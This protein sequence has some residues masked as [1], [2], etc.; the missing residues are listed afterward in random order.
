MLFPYNPHSKLAILK[1]SGGTAAFTSQCL[2]L[3]VEIGP[4]LAAQKLGSIRM[5]TNLSP[6]QHCLLELHCQS[7][8]ID[9]VTLQQWAKKEL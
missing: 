7:G 1:T 8:H 6:A 5:N 9:M 4:R 2:G 3:N